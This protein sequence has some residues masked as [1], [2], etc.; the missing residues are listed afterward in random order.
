MVRDDSPQRLRHG[1]FLVGEA[2]ALGVSRDRLRCNDFQRVGRGL[3]AWSRTQISEYLLAAALCR[4][5]PGAVVS[6]DSAGRLWGMPMEHSRDAWRPGMPIHLMA[7]PGRRMRS[8]EL[9][10]W[11]YGGLDDDDVVHVDGTRGYG[12]WVPNDEKHRYILRVTSRSR[13]WFDLTRSLPLDWAVAQADHLLR[14]P[15]EQFE[16]RTRP[17]ATRESLEH[18]LRRCRG[19]A[20]AKRGRK[21]LSFARVG[22]DSPA[23][24]RCR[25]A[26]RFGRLPE[27]ELNARH[28]ADDGS[29]VAQTDFTFRKFGVV[30][31]Y[32]GAVHFEGDAAQRGQRRTIRLRGLGLIDLHLF[33]DDLPRP[34]PGESDESVMR[35]LATCPAVTVVAEELRRQGWRR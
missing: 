34:I 16:R 26:F 20:G 19:R 11:H 25:L 2:L 32:D 13:T 3:Y 7:P 24:T 35:R 18:L 8:T 9:I 6:H 27:P 12:G 1:V 29:V 21:I 14:I 10:T 4:Q 5:Y 33:R 31:E 23:E 30:V 22:A 28:L 15:R 17:Y